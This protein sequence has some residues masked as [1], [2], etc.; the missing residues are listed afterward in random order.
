[1]SETIMYATIIII[2][3]VNSYNV[4]DDY[5]LVTNQSNLLLW[6]NHQHT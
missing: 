4:Y 1:M 3:G 2:Q 5:I 6:V